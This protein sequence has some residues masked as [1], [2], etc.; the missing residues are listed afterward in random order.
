MVS[1]SFRDRA[2]AAVVPCA[3]GRGLGPIP[4]IASDVL[5]YRT[6]FGELMLSRRLFILRF[7]CS[8]KADEEREGLNS[9]RDKNARHEPW[10]GGGGEELSAYVTSDVSYC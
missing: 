4:Q 1:R 3:A 2:Q 9:S 10:L 8:M 5:Q 6:G 7:L